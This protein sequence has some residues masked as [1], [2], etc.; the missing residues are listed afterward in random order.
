MLNLTKNSIALNEILHTSKRMIS[1]GVIGKKNM[2]YYKVCD[3]RIGRIK[4]LPEITEQ[5]N[6][7][8]YINCTR[9]IFQHGT[10]QSVSGKRL[11]R[12]LSAAIKT[13]QF[14]RRFFYSGENN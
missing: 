13:G 2:W 8:G 12:L 10:Q 5:L 4:V 14:E 9:R 7:Q 1:L 6:T 3:G 11:V